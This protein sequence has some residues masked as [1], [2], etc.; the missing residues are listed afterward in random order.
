MSDKRGMD[1]Q[2]VESLLQNLRTGATNLDTL[3][4][5]V[6]GL[7]SPLENCWEG[8]ESAA[9]VAYLSKLATTMEQMSKEVMKIHDWVDKT[10]EN[11][12]LA[13]NKGVQAYSGKA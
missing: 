9:C 4:R 13:A 8:K 7:K 1:I 3:T 5:D 2:Q 10:R 6:A 11:Y 12:D